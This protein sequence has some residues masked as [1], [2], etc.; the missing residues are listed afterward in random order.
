MSSGKLIT[1]DPSDLAKKD[2]PETSK[3]AA[4]EVAPVYEDA[5]APQIYEHLLDLLPDGRTA[6]QVAQELG[7]GYETVSS[8]MSI[9]E[10][11]EP[12]LLTK[13]VVDMDDDFKPI[14]ARRKNNPGKTADIR[15]AVPKKS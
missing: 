5:I 6:K 9:M 10:K 14:Y 8:C 12:P 3:M 1:V 13:K 7:I 15:Y 11:A 4:V 2:G